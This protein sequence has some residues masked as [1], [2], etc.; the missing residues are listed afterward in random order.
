MPHLNQTSGLVSLLGNVVYTSTTGWY[1]YVYKRLIDIQIGAQNNSQRLHCAATFVVMWRFYKVSTSLC[2][3][4]YV[5]LTCYS[6]NQLFID[7][8]LY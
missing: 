5:V 6:L 8:R 4:M 7:K 3:N 1:I 2:E